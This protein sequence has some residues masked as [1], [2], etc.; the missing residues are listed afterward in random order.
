MNKKIIIHIMILIISI[1]TIYLTM[2]K[3][4]TKEII[5]DN[6]INEENIINIIENANYK[7]N[8]ENEIKQDKKCLIMKKE[9][10]KV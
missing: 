4:D 10:E 2:N 5:E 7:C 1:T 3:N 8:K 9:Q 6:I